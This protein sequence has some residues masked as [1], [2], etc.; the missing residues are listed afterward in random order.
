MRADKSGPL[1][2][3]CHAFAGA[4]R[5]WADPE[6]IVDYELNPQGQIVALDFNIRLKCL[7][8]IHSAH[9]WRLY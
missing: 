6:R 7:P 3:D 4:G 2:I 8:L 1:V 5:T 9:Q